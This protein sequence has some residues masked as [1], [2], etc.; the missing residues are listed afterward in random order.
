MER[1][2]EFRWRRTTRPERTVIHAAALQDHFARALKLDVQMRQVRLV[3]QNGSR[4]DLIGPSGAN[5]RRRDQVPSA[6]PCRT[7]GTTS[8]NKFKTIGIREQQTASARSE[9]TTVTSKRGNSFTTATA[10]GSNNNPDENTFERGVPW[11]CERCTCFNR[12]GPP[13]CE[14][15]GSS[16]K[17]QLRQ[18]ARADRD[19]RTLA[20]RLGLM[21]GPPAKLSKAEWRALEQ[22]SEA[23]KDSFEPCAICQEHF[24]AGQQLLLSCSHV[25][26]KACLES[27]ERFVRSKERCCP[28]CRKANYEKR[29][30]KLGIKAHRQRSATQIQ[31]VFRGYIARK[32]FRARLSAYYAAGKGTEHQRHK[33]FANKL[34][35][36]SLR[37]E[38]AVY[39]QEDSI[40]RLFAEL[41]CSITASRRILGAPNEELPLIIGPEQ[42]EGILRTLLNREGDE[43]ECAICMAP[44]VLQKISLKPQHE[45]PE[46]NDQK[47][48]ACLLS[49]SHCFHQHCIEAFERFSIEKAATCP[50]CRS[51][52]A[53]KIA[54]NTEAN[55]QS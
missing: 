48:I 40:D 45:G 39:A 50:M 31:T 47:R 1:R 28:L 16:R 41:D 6:K 49:C 24:G 34:Q 35:S 15:C 37:L 23:R 4:V 21:Q 27:F 26:H 51:Q 44:I 29:S 7:E 5:R 53:A 2:D 14:A 42:W 10:A 43:C 3:H 9:S 32:G 46:I 11:T 52:Y 19:Q 13:R 17:A 30:V 12:S 36:V 55:I 25:F 18:L 33:F 38:R 22:A 54:L 20:Q 8:E